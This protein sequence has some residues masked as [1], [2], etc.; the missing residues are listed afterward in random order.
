MQRE[1]VGKQ[2]FAMSFRQDKK[3]SD[4]K[5]L[6]MPLF[7]EL[8]LYLNYFKQLRRRRKVLPESSVIVFGA[9]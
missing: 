8:P 9:K 5:T 2:M 4:I 3:G 1:N 7:Q 6:A